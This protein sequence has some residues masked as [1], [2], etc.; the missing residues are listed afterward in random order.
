MQFATIFRE[1][2]HIAKLGD[3]R[4]SRGYYYTIVKEWREYDEADENL[5]NTWTDEEIWV[6]YPDGIFE[7]HHLKDKEHVE[8]ICPGLFNRSRYDA[9]V[10]MMK[11]FKTE[12]RDELEYDEANRETLPLISDEELDE[13]EGKT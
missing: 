9:F 8:E 5:V 10:E 7:Y 13:L 2:P 1:G 12:W 4:E 6:L 3:G 11:G